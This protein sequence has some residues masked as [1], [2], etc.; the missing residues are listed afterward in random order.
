M[1]H[2]PKCWNKISFSY[3]FKYFIS[4][5]LFG[6]ALFLSVCGIRRLIVAVSFLKQIERFARVFQIFKKYKVKY[7]IMHFYYGLKF[8]L[9]KENTV[10]E[11]NVIVIVT[12]IY[13]NFSTNIGL[14][15]S[16][17]V[18]MI[19]QEAEWLCFQNQ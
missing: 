16:V 7:R 17:L 18:I 4:K 12:L 5:R 2:T 13:I 10:L 19:S 11:V 1:K 15:K 8:H 9:C 6:T 3:D 14:W